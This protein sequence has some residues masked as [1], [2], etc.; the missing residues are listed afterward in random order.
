[1]M[2]ETTLSGCLRARTAS[3]R[4]PSS[5]VGAWRYRSSASSAPTRSPARTLSASPV[6]LGMIKAQ[7]SVERREVE[8]RGVLVERPQ[9]L[10]LV[11]AKKV[12]N[13]IAQVPPGDR[14]AR[15]IVRIVGA[16]HIGGMRDARVARTLQ[17]LN[18]LRRHGVRPSSPE[19]VDE[20]QT[21]R[22]RPQRTEV[23]LL[24]CGLRIADCGR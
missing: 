8:L 2:Y 23:E 9:A 6:T 17:R 11:V 3:A 1:M 19:G 21:G 16:R 18:L 10:E 20:R 24:N 15:R 5:A 13:I 14:F 4:R 12:L 22:P 7:R